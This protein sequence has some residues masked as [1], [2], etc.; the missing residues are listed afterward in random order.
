MPR[1]KKLTALETTI[2][3][4]Y[5]AGGSLTLLALVYKVSPGTIRSILKRHGVVLRRQGRKKK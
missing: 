3:E 4:G 2:V 5:Q 1:V